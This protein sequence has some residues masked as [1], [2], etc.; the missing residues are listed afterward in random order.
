MPVL[1][2]LEATRLIAAGRLASPPAILLVTA[3]GRD[4]TLAAALVDSDP[5]HR[6]QL[7]SKPVTASA[8]LSAIGETTGRAVSPP[9]PP[10]RR[11]GATPAAMVWLTGTRLL[12]VEDDPVSRDPGAELRAPPAWT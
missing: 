6:P 3:F 7:L 5:R 4:A 11:G 12:V 9:S 2:G 1:N 10:P 8:L